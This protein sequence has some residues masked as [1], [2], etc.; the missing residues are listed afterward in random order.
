MATRNL[1]TRMCTPAASTLRRRLD[2]RFISSFRS[3]VQQQRGSNGVS[4]EFANEMAYLT[5]E[6]SKVTFSLR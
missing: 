5:E 2:S 4:K 1:V 3:Q 6:M